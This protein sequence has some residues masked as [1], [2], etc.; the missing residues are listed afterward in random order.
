MSRRDARYSVLTQ[1][2]TRECSLLIAL[3]DGESSLLPSG[4]ADTVL[5]YLGVRTERNKDDTRLHFLDAPAEHELPARSVYWIPAARAKACPAPVR[6]SPCF[7]AAFSDNTLL[8]FPK[9]R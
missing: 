2:L 9:W 8:R 7:L 1:T 5:R 3:W 4:T 6:G